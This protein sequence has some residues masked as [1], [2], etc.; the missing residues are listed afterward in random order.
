[1]HAKG[2]VFAKYAGVGA[3]ATGM[4]YLVVIG[5][6]EALRRPAWEAALCGAVA[7]GVVAYF[8]N[9]RF[10]FCSPRAH[11]SALSRFALVALAGA[12]LQSAVVGLGTET[13]RLHYL[14]AQALATGLVFLITFLVNRRWTFH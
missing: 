8:G 4:H 7:G 1:M 11:R 12:G 3:V 9:H 14:V 10:T 13:L 6:V 5:A 2:Q